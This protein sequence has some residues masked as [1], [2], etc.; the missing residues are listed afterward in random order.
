MRVGIQEWSQFDRRGGLIF[1]SLAPAKAPAPH[2]G[3]VKAGSYRAANS[4]GNVLDII[5]GEL[6]RAQSL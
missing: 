4:G 2:S 5:A 3:R 1:D 6:V